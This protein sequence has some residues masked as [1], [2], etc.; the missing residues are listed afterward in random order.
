MQYTYKKLLRGPDVYDSRTG[1]REGMEIRQL[2]LY[3]VNSDGYLETGFG[4]LPKLSG[5]LGRAGHDVRFH[6]ITPPAP[7]R[8]LCYEL[9]W[10]NVWRHNVQFRPRQMDAVMSVVNNP[11]GIINAPTG[12]GKTWLLYVLA[13]LYPHAK[14]AV[15]VKSVEVAEKIVRRLTAV[16]P[17]VGFVSGKG[18]KSVG[19]LTVYTAGSMHHCDGD[20]DFLFADECVTG[21]ADIATPAGTTKLKNVVDG[22]EVLCYCLLYT[23]PSPRDS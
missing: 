4:F 17:N 20:V 19:R 3:K 16:M 11:G 5:V 6:D 7:D 13:L 18:K 12:F 14:I 8:P 15:V 1:S 10:Q 2:R 22:D 23:S 21:D 9:D